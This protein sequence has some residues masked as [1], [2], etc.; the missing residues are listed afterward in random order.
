MHQERR[1]SRWR[2]HLSKLG[3]G[4][5]HH[6]WMR[7][8]AS[9]PAARLDHRGVGWLLGDGS[10]VVALDAKGAD[11][12]TPPGGHSRFLRRIQ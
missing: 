3:T 8:D 10:R 7:V 11:I 1:R 5:R 2:S 9:H 6:R 12:K 4:S